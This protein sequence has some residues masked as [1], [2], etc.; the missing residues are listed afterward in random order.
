MKSIRLNRTALSLAVL[1]PFLASAARAETFFNAWAQ[2]YLIGAEQSQGAKAIALDSRGNVIVTGFDLN[3]AGGDS[4]A[5][6]VKYNGAD[7][8]IVWERTLSATNDV[9]P[10]SIA[11]DSNDAV[12]ITGRRNSSG[13]DDFFVMKYNADGSLATGFSSLGLAAPVVY[14]G[15]AGGSDIP[16]K[17]VIDG[18]NNIIVAGTSFGSGTS[19]DFYVKKYSPAGAALFEVRTST[20]RL[21]DATDIAVG[22]DN[23]IIAVGSLTVASADT[24]FHVRKLTPTFGSG[25]V[26]KT[27]DTGGRGGAVAVVVDQINGDIYA[28]GLINNVTGEQGFYTVKYDTA[29]VFQWEAIVQPTASDFSGTPT[30]IALG[31]DRNP[32]VTGYLRDVSGKFY[33]RTIKY[34]GSP[35]G[36]TGVVIWDVSDSGFIQEETLSRKVA[37]DAAN[38][39]V[40]L[41]ESVNSHAGSSSTNKDVYVAKY[42]GASGTLLFV[43]GFN[44][45]FSS[46]D[47]KGTDLAVDPFGDISITSTPFRVQ[48]PQNTSS[49]RTEIATLKFNRFLA[50]SGDDFPDDLPGVPDSATFFSSGAP[51]IGNDGSAAA[52]ILFAVGKSKRNAIL[53]QGS[54]GGSTLPVV[55]GVDAPD[56]TGAAEGKFASFS[57]PVVSPNGNFAFVGKLS[58]VP[59]SNSGGVWQSI[60]GALRRVLQQGTPITGLSNLTFS[61]ASSIAMRDGQLLVLAKISGSPSTNIAL[62]GINTAGTATLLLQKGVTM[63]TVGSDEPSLVKTITALSPAPLSPGDGRWQATSGSVVARVVLASKR[64]VTVRITTAGV[65]TPVIATGAE[66]AGLPA[67]SVKSLGLPAVSTGPRVT[68]LVT[69]APTAGIVTPSSDTVLIYNAGA[70]TFTPYAREGENLPLETGLQNFTYG[71]L[72]DPVIATVNNAPAVA[73]LATLKGQGVKGNNNRALIYGSPLSTL[74]TAARTGF[75]APSAPSETLTTYSAISAFAMPNGTAAGPIFVAKLAGAGTSAK[76]NIGLFAIDSTGAPRRL[77]RTGQVIGDRTVKSFLLLK[78]VPQA[79]SAARSFNNASSVAVSI[80]FTNKETALL[81]LSIP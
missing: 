72:S 79:F 26:A 47:D 44:G 7:G 40:I 56:N 57:D 21:D 65:V 37:V 63:V 5:Y 81:R 53:V 25:F 68:T 34:Q 23:S 31:P 59:K 24:R 54:G 71:G 38:N 42:D 6:T 55:Q 32:V 76:N 49:G 74:Q 66:A 13:D 28:T 29:G 64:A 17:V 75:P 11:I 67:A 33:A 22:P 39:V 50:S 62:I 46:S 45:S 77:L 48:S 16:A 8:S 41:G 19:G 30:D 10:T 43:G 20:P 51:A 69:L 35:I 9:E 60:G 70:A 52:K 3:G 73:F 27:V 4:T 2:E 12:I 58:G 78:A 1:L 18:A 15:T 14:D 61:S 36:D 80:N